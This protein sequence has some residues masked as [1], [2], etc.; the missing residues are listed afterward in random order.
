[1]SQTRMKK[2]TPEQEALIPLY[3][4]KWKAIALSTE[5]LDRQKAKAAVRAV[6]A[7]MGKKEPEIRFFSSP[8]AGKVELLAQPP[9]QLAQQLGAPLLTMPFSFELSGELEKQLEEP[10]WQQL[11]IQLKLNEQLQPVLQPMALLIQQLGGQM[12]EQEWQRLGQLQEQLHSQLL[13]YLWKQHQEQLRSQLRKQLGGE[14][15]VQVGDSLWHQVGEPLWKHVAEPVLDRILHQPPIQEW[16]QELRQQLFPW[17][18]MVDGIGLM[19]GLLRSDLETSSASLIDFCISVLNCDLDKKKWSA[20]QS[21]IKDCGWVFPFEKTCLAC[22]RPTKL[23]FDNENRLHAEGEPAIQFVDGYSLYAYQ[24]VIL[25]EKYGRIHPHQWRSQWLLE[26]QNAELRRVLIQGIGYARICQELQVIELDTWRE[27]TLLRID[28]DID[29]EAIY[30]L[31]MT[32]PSTGYIHALRV[33]PDMQSAREAIR[34]ANWGVDPEEF[35]GE[36]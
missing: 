20:L 19:Y 2:L 7:V 12:S 28:N 34:W 4:E 3:R 29:V 23:S 18:Q 17:F 24:N 14:L 22:D 1:M 5:P 33:P 13:R 8:N 6:Y 11:G 35:S 21:L 26:E 15:L 27:Y 16:E 31:K 9:R 32:C 25:P 30:L 10:L 36:T